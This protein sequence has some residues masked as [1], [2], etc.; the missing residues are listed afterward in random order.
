MSFV[1]H[2][3]ERRLRAV[4]RAVVSPGIWLLIAAQLLYPLLRQTGMLAG[5]GAGTPDLAGS[6]VF[7]LVAMLVLYLQAGVFEA[8][9]RSRETV[10]V[11][12]VLKAGK[13]RFADF[14]WLALKAGLL[15]GLVLGLILTA[16][17]LVSGKPPESEMNR[18]SGFFAA[19]F[20]ALPILLLWWLPSVF[21]TADFR[22]IASLQTARRELTSRPARSVFPAVLVLL[23]PLVLLAIP[24]DTIWPVLLGL[25]ALGM[26]AIWV[27]DIYC[28]EWLRDKGNSAGGSHPVTGTTAGHDQNH[29]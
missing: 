15:F 28:I 24:A 27:A 21:V 26:L 10:S 8:L 17:M 20:I 6:L 14:I 2:E 18:L 29:P 19:I 13:T 9:V 12:E 11:A 16:L 1:P 3:S 5:Q 4:V 25:E 23:P 22:L 7:G